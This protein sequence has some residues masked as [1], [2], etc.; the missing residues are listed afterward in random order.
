MYGCLKRLFQVTVNGETYHVEIEEKG[1]PVVQLHTVEPAANKVRKSLPRPFPVQQEN[2]TLQTHSITAPMPGKIIEVNVKPG[3][4]VTKGQVLLII[5]AM[6]MENEI[7]TPISGTVQEVHVQPGT[8]VATGQ[9][10]VI[11]G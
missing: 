3:Q 9:L 4:K 5:E 11:L 8:S 2:N 1:E 10:L 7:T 6:K